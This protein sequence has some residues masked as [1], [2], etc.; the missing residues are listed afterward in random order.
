MISCTAGVSFFFFLTAALQLCLIIHIVSTAACNNHSRISFSQLDPAGF[1]QTWLTGRDNAKSFP[2]GRKRSNQISRRAF[3]VPCLQI[4]SACAVLHFQHARHPSSNVSKFARKSSL[5]QSRLGRA[6][7]SSLLLATLSNRQM[8]DCSS[9]APVRLNFSLRHL[10]T[11]SS[12]L[13]RRLARSA[14]QIDFLGATPPGSFLFS[15]KTCRRISASVLMQ[16]A[17]LSQALHLPH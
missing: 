1:T 15:A 13:I 16:P 3:Q 8:R 12:P 2:T 14:S 5:R 9:L 6:S 17:K 4:E 7:L 10:V 11:Y